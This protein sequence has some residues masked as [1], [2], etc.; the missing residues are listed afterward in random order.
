MTNAYRKRYAFAMK[1]RQTY[2]ERLY[3]LMG[4]NHGVITIA[5]ASEVGVPAV[6]LRKLTQRGALERVGRGVYRIP[7]ADLNDWEHAAELLSS[8]GGSAYIRGSS[9]LQLLNIGVSNP[10]FTEVATTKRFRKSPPFG[11]RVVQAR[12]SDSVVNMRGLRVQSLAQVLSELMPVTIP[13]RMQTDI[14]EALDLQLIAKSEYDKLMREF[15]T[16]FSQ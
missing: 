6:E 9:V 16:R 12:K 8:V 2:R 10:R 4:V 3:E 13:S 1:T 5:M 11:A 14:Q 15:E 7:F